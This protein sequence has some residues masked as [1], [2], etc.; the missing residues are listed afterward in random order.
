MYALPVEGDGVHGSLET[1]KMSLEVVMFST[2]LA[3][4][5]AG[6]SI[7]NGLESRRQR[8]VIE[9]EIARLETAQKGGAV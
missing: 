6:F 3:G 7:A 1:A 2:W 5:V 8:K 4:I 9:A